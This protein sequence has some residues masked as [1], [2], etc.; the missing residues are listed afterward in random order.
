MNVLDVLKRVI[1]TDPDAIEKKRKKRD[2]DAT[3]QD[4]CWES[5]D[6]VRA[7]RKRREEQGR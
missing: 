6:K 3:V 5:D 7:G 2:S 4:W 1:G